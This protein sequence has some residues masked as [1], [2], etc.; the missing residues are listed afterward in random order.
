MY[1]YIYRDIKRDTYDILLMERERESARETF[2]I[3]LC[4][5]FFLGRDY[6]AITYDERERERERARKNTHM[7]LLH[8][9]V[10]TLDI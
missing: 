10:E 5:V 1:R 4:G 2:H 7:K 3:F 9:V 6:R 8:D